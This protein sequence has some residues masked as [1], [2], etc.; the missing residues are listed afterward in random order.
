MSALS[1]L[2]C[3]D[4]AQ[5]RPIADP[6]E[7]IAQLPPLLRERFATQAGRSEMERALEDAARLRDEGRARK[8]H[9]RP[10]IRQEVQDLEDRL[11][12]QQLLRDEAKAHAPDEATLKKFW[13]E[14]QSLFRQPERV[15]VG[16]VFVAQR[17]DLPAART[18]ASALRKRWTGG[19]AL[20]SVAKDG[21]GGERVRG[22]DMGFLKADHPDR[23][24]AKA[25]FALGAGEI[26]EPLPTEGGVS[27]LS[28]L[29]RSPAHAVPF[30]E[31]RA[32]VEARMK[33]L[34][35]RRAFEQLITRLREAPR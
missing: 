20:A 26:S 34:L 4:D 19:E 25:A 3:G 35:E 28:V 17:G 10:E 23:A 31:A 18:K 15:R 5:E 29:E 21:D 9:E 7:K 13:D 2:A 8:I 33:P 30:P 11:T 6:D 12:I 22:G 16:R 32:D 1:R 14:N 27:V 24:L